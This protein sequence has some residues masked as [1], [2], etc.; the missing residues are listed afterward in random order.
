MCRICGAANRGWPFTQ[1]IS[2]KSQLIRGE[3]GFGLA[4]SLVAIALL[5]TAVISLTA[6]L[7]TGSLGVGAMREGATA[8]S[9]TQSQLAYTKSYPYDSGATTY[10]SVADFDDTYNPN[11]VTMPAG[12]SILVEAETTRDQNS[13]IQKITTSV[14]Y[15]GTTILAVEDFKVDR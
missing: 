8:Q 2:S 6:A 12:Y 9:L 13:S 11:P 1:W 3:K 5:A 15:G 14:V 10:P 4:E 7:S